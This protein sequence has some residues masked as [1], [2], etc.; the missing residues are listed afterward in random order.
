MFRG[1]GLSIQEWRV[2]EIKIACSGTWRGWEEHKP[3]AGVSIWVLLV[4]GLCSAHIQ[5][6]VRLG[7]PVPDLSSPTQVDLYIM[8]VLCLR[9][10]H[11]EK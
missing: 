5:A 1:S 3:G 4:L 11:A 8:S 7:Q 6:F 9:G 10:E 2:R